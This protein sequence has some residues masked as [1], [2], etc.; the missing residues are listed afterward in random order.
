MNFRGLFQAEFYCDP[1]ICKIKFNSQSFVGSEEKKC[2]L[3]RI[4]EGEQVNSFYN[5]TIG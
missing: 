5:V 1:M 3:G 4:Y 2:A